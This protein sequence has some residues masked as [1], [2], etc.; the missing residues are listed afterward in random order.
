MGSSYLIHLGDLRFTAALAGA[1]T[2]WLLA[3]RSCRPACWWCVEYGAAMSAVTISKILY[4]GWGLQ[5]SALHF[6]A[7]SGHA[8]GTAAVLPVVFY[9]LAIPFGR[10]NANFA[11]AAGWIVSIAVALALV[12]QGEHTPSEAFAGWCLGVMASAATWLKLRQTEIA[13]SRSGMGAAFVLMALI[14][15]CLHTVPVGRWMN[16]TA[17]VLSG[18]QRTHAWND[19]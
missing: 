4:L 2:V 15:T 9:L 7:A 8:A 12:M 1:V 16:K 11:L 10:N 5:I 17:L 13:P 6:K 19:C 14:A 18:E 3:A